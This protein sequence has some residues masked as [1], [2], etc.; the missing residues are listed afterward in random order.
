MT[1]ADAP[2][3]NLTTPTTARATAGSAIAQR[4]LGP[5]VLFD[6]DYTRAAMAIRPWPGNNRRIP[7]PGIVVAVNLRPGG[8]M[9]IVEQDADI[10]LPVDRVAA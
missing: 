6:P 9:P 1:P 3:R 2:G 4:M 10:T 8:P 5:D 7:S